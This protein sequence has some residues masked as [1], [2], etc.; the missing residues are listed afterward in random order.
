MKKIL[1]TTLSIF[2][3]SYAAL[4]QGPG[5]PP[6][7]IPMDGGIAYFLAAAAIGGLGFLLTKKK[8]G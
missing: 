2:S 8:K 5:G 6:P 4:A 3:V 7:G 1:T